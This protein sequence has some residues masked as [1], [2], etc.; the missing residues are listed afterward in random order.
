MGNQGKAAQCLLP[1]EM[2]HMHHI[3]SAKQRTVENRM[4]DDDLRFVGKRR[5]RPPGLDAT[6]LT[7]VGKAEVIVQCRDDEQ[8]AVEAI[9][10]HRLLVIVVRQVA[11][12]GECGK[13]FLG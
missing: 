10:G 6:I 5:L 4:G 2:F 13:R 3:A 7:A 9:D 1:E 11:I 12:V 8:L